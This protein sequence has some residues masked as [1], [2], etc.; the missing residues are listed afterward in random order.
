MY[1]AHLSMSVCVC[2]WFI[3]MILQ[4]EC[5]VLC[6]VDAQLHRIS[7]KVV[8]CVLKAFKRQRKRMRI[9]ANVNMDVFY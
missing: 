8:G 6:G 5:V 3:T 7:R 4:C 9:L 2:T 1:F